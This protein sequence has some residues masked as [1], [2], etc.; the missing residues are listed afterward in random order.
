LLSSQYHN[1]LDV[2][3]L[4]LLLCCCKSLLS[5]DFAVTATVFQILGDQHD[6]NDDDSDSELVTATVTILIMMIV[7]VTAEMIIRARM[8]V[9]VHWQQQ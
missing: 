8:K 3:N 4:I 7:R 5:L 1:F 2:F 6:D 9:I